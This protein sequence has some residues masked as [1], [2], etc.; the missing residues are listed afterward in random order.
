MTAQHEEIEPVVE[1]LKFSTTPDTPR[2]TT[3]D[4]IPFQLDDDET[5]LWAE[6]PKMATLLQLTG[7]IQQILDP[8]ANLNIQ[9]GAAAAIQD[10]VNVC[11]DG[12]TRVYLQERFDDPDDQLDI[13]DL[14]PVVQH[15]VGRWYGRP[16][17][18]LSGSSG[19][20]P[21]SGKRSTA[22]RRSQG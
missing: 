14:M 8:T 17:G 15:F 12:P 1:P 22:R 21:K 16:T 5:M 4:R 7:S 3:G 18:S 9:L 11:F 20:R 2:D 19:G 10:F 6:R 13:T